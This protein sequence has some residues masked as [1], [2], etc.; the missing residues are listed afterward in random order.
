M[1]DNFA[2]YD[3]NNKDGDDDNNNDNCNHR[4]KNAANGQQSALSHGYDIG[5]KQSIGSK[6]VHFWPPLLGSF[7]DRHFWGPLLAA[8]FGVLF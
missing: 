6:T 3:D 7:F 1:S 8:T 4:D 2:D 5:Q